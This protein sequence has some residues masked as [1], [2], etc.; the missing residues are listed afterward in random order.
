MMMK[1]IKGSLNKRHNMLMEWKSQYSKAINSP[2]IEFNVISIK[3]PSFLETQT[4]YSRINMETHKSRIAKT[5][6]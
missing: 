3:M 2:Q 6:F 4:T 5:I 1:E